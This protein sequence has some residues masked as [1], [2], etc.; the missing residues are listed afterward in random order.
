MGVTFLYLLS[1]QSERI[2]F[3]DERDK[4]ILYESD[5]EFLNDYENYQDLIEAF[6][7]ATNKD[8][9][10]R[11]KL[12]V[13]RKVIADFLETLSETTNI[14]FRVTPGLREKVDK[15]NNYQGQGLRVKRHI[16]S[17]LKADLGILYIKKHTKNNPHKEK[18]NRLNVEICIEGLAK[19]YQG[20]IEL[21]EPNYIVIY[22][23][24]SV[25]NPRSQEIIIENGV[26]IKVEPIVEIDSNLRRKSDLTD[27]IYQ[28]WE[29]EEQVEKE[30]EN[31]QALAAMFEQWQS[32]I[33]IE[34]EIIQEQKATFVYIQKFYEQ[35]RQIVI[36]TLR[37]AI[38]VEDLEKITSTPL[39]VTISTTKESSSSRKKSKQL[40]IGDIIDGEKSSNGELIEK[41]HI[42]IGDFRPDEIIQS[43]SDT[44]K[45]ETNLQD[46]ESEIEK[47]LQEF[48]I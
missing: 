35:Q 47:R 9:E 22:G 20:F 36:V 29:K 6:K 42:S 10:K 44:G 18:E 13:L 26:E 19:I 48:R 23:Q 40:P 37:E 33:D 25:F 4:T 45:I 8:H 11:P 24:Q 3:Q 46:Q 15:S 5:E 2:R 16:E 28:I 17:D 12:D 38:S 41:L 1:T 27:L 43:I 7:T 34:K 39:P 21:D 31:N 14:V 32:V 30:K